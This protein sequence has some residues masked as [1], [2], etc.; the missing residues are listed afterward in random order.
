MY[1]GFAIVNV[2]VLWYLIELLVLRGTRGE[3]RFGP[4]PL[5]GSPQ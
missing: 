1:S 3:N 2:L 5:A 4:D